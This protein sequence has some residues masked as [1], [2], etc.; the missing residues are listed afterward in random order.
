MKTFKDLQFKPHQTGDGLHGL[1]FFPNGYGI[2]VVRFMMPISHRGYGSYTDNENE[3]E[4]A[5]LVGN[6]DGWE[7]TY[8]TPI[9][10]DVIGH[11]E[12][13][14]VTEIMKQIQELPALIKTKPLAA[15]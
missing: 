1:A 10:D 12:E 4:V 6:V 8:D 3:W 2:S 13:S 15:K 9:T 7:L 11:L 14:E 5:I